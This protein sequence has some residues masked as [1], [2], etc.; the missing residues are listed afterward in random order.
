M[1]ILASVF[2]KRMGLCVAAVVLAVGMVGCSGKGKAG[3]VEELRLGMDAAV[4]QGNWR[5]A[6][7]HAKAALAADPE[8][9]TA[10]TLLALVNENLSDK[11]GAM[12]G[13]TQ[14][15]KLAPGDFLASYSLGRMQFYKKDY[16]LAF[17][18]LSNAGTAR[19]DDLN[20]QVL[21]FQCAAKLQNSKTYDPYFKALWAR[22][23]F[24]NKPELCNEL[25]LF[26]LS[27]QPQTRQDLSKAAKC[28]GMALKAAPENP[29]VLANI[30]VFYDTAADSPDKAKVMYRKFIKAASLNP[31]FEARANDARKRLA[32]LAKK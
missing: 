18:N 24:R 31:A 30:A 9:I 3:A 17:E 8:N 6:K 1:R 13:L 25:A 32:T 22:E 12:K 10:M 15:L 23:Q 20:T 14:A 27:K 26:Y 4:N 7:A 11:E 19:P 21:L 2:G 5:E 16:E 28:L 29:T